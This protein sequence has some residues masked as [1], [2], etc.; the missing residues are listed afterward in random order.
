M[1]YSKAENVFSFFFQ[2][3]K[4]AFRVILI[5]N[6]TVFGRSVCFPTPFKNIAQLSIHFLFHAAEIDTGQLIIHGK[7]ILCV[8]GRG[9]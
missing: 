5:S 8:T 1:L 6:H 7:L 4:S 2:L 9:K 3:E